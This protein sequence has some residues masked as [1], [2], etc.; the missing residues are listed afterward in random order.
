MSIEEIMKS[1]LIV[2][3]FVSV[4]G[5]QSSEAITVNSDNMN[6]LIKIEKMLL[7]ELYNYIAAEKMRYGS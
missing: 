4:N 6:G 1:L 5:T 3:W 7:N 2:L